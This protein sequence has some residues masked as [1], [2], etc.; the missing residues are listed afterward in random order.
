L[1]SRGVFK[2]SPYSYRPALQKFCYPKLFALLDW[3]FL[4]RNDGGFEVDFSGEN[5]D[6]RFIVKLSEE[7][8]ISTPTRSPKIKS[9]RRQTHRNE[10][11]WTPIAVVGRNNFCIICRRRTLAL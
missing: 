6:R 8:R 7:K 4:V 5:E 9:T 1:G 3:S 10:A 11:A 2:S